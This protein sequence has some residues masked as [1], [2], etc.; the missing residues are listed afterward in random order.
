VRRVPLGAV[1]GYRDPDPATASAA[2]AT[3]SA[4]PPAE[5]GALPAQLLDLV[6]RARLVRDL[7]EAA[8]LVS[9]LAA[10]PGIG[11]L[12]LVPPGTRLPA[13][14]P[15]ASAW[16]LGS[17][18]GAS[19]LLATVEVD[20]P[21][22]HRRVAAF[23]G[24]LDGALRRAPQRRAGD[25][26]GADAGQQARALDAVLSNAP[27]LVLTVHPDCTWTAETAAIRRLLHD[28]AAELAADGPAALVHPTDRELARAVFQAALE[29]RDPTGPVRLR[30][31]TPDERWTSLQVVVRSLLDDPDV[32]GVVWYAFEAPSPGPPTAADLRRVTRS[33]DTVSE[34]LVRITTHLIRTP[35]TAVISFADLLGDDPELGAGQRELVRAVQRNADR[36]RIVA[37]DLLL[38]MRMS[39][40][41]IRLHPVALSAE[42]LIRSV[43]ADHRAAAQRTGVHLH[44]LVTGGY[45][46]R[47]DEAWLRRAIGALLERALRVSGT[48]G[49]VAVAATG[50]SDGWDVEVRD[51]GTATEADLMALSGRLV[52]HHGPEPVWAHHFGFELLTMRATI[53]RHGG[54]VRAG[55]SAEGGTSVR[56]WLPAA[57]DR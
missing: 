55:R 27:A 20:E 53:L 18:A 40:G 28:M 21:A 10:L 36:L 39:S 42:D 3:A 56:L 52:R 6:G 38:L 13:I 50:D 9:A 34:E 37:D 2:P 43:V 31:R 23:A 8:A 7:D 29:G 48:G 32:H 12:T 35:L 14:P 47:A 44:Y 11:P 51:A 45:P 25:R 1:P 24:A 33:Y 17:G 22:V 26:P 41:A 49:E 30:I 57:R 46:V 54:R 19:V 5:P 16:P 4:A 15:G